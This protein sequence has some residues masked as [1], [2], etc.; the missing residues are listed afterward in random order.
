MLEI[1]CFALE[2]TDYKL[3]TVIYLISTILCLASRYCGL[4]TYRN[5]PLVFKTDGFTST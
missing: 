3:E 4:Q 5:P 2:L 1:I